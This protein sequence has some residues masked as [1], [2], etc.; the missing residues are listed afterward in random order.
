MVADLI[1]GTDSKLHAVLIAST[2]K[3]TTTRTDN[4]ALNLFIYA[5][6]PNFF[7]FFE[8][9]NKS[10]FILQKVSYFPESNR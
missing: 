9:K 6:P 7:I 10:I 4:N 3:M 8:I 5:S 2:N 1:H